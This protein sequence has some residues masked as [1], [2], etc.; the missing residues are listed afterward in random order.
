M[1]AYVIYNRFESERN[2][3]FINELIKEFN[4]LGIKLI[5][6]I[7]EYFK[8]GVDNKSLF[9]KN[10]IIDFPIF[11]INRTNNYLLSAQ[12]ESLGIRVFNNSRVSQMSNNKF[13]T[14]LT[15]SKYGVP[16]L[17]T[18][19]INNDTLNSI[20]KFPVVIKPIDGKG[21]KD[22][23]LCNN[24]DELS[25]N[26]NKFKYI[27]FI[28]QEFANNSGKDL[29]VYV[30]GNSIYKAVLRVS[31][32][33]FISNYCLG[34]DAIIYNLNDNETKLVNKIIESD[35]FDYVGIDFLFHNNELVLNEIEDSVGARMLYD[36]T[37]LNVAHDFA[38]YVYSIL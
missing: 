8:L 3:W 20:D 35:N 28:V 34:N 38:K 5:L 7:E 19:L 17:N 16:L 18:K 13:L 32:G 24:K 14:Y 9:Y 4:N 37:D 25:V 2:A 12:I 10:S 29:R 15:M 21:G 27:D 33:G 1:L 23:Y 30:L 11:V 22:V 31:K 26:S 36:K 6:I